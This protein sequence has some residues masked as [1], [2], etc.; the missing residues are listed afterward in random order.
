[1]S[2]RVFLVTKKRRRVG[3]IDYTPFILLAVIGGAG[4]FAYQ[5]IFNSPGSQANTDN[6]NSV[7][8]GT[9][10]SLASD[11]ANLKA[12][13]YQQSASNSQLSGYA[14]QIWRLGQKESGNASTEDQDTIVGI[15]SNI[16]NDLDLDL[17]MQYFGTKNVATGFWTS[18]N[19]LGKNCVAID[20]PAFIRGVLDSDHI[21]TANQDLSGNG[22]SYQF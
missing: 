13:G 11:I 15:I 4:Y 18:C 7:N 16:N 22:L 6:N 21:A 2:I 20:F 12:A 17:M 3:S 10:S 5:A 8:S 1:M 19:I 14:D 9:T